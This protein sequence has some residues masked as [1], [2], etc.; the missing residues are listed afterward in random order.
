MDEEKRPQH[1]EQSEPPQKEEYPETPLRT[2]IF[3]WIGV[4]FMVLLV[5]MYT[6]SMATGKIFAW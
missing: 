6:Y 2:R 4:I 1:F 3:A 5:I